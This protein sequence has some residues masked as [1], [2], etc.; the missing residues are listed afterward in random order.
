MPPSDGVD[1]ILLFSS[2][3]SYYVR[4]ERHLGEHSVQPIMVK[5]RKYK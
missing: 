1:Q 4:A 2:K 3:E 5:P